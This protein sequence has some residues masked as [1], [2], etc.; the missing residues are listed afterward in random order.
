MRIETTTFEPIAVY[1]TFDVYL[2][3]A[4]ACAI[5]VGELCYGRINWFNVVSGY[6]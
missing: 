4:L 5:K 1:I 2:A 6:M 3:K